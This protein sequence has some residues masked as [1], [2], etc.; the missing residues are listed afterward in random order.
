MIHKSLLNYLFGIL[1]FIDIKLDASLGKQSHG[2]IVIIDV[3]WSDDP[4]GYVKPDLK[5]G[6]NTDDINAIVMRYFE[7]IWKKF[8]VVVSLLCDL[9]ILKI[10][11]H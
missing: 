2:M 6:Q 1:A 8:L 11:L 5:W 9:S 4:L 10:G 3:W 7:A